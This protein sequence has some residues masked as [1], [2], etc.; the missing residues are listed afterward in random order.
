LSIT[1]T[2]VRRADLRFIEAADALRRY[3]G[4][5]WVVTAEPDAT[6]RIVPDGSTAISIQLQKSGT[7]GWVL[8]GPMVR[9]EERRFRSRAMLIGVRLRP[10]VAFLVSGIAAHTIVGRHVRLS[11]T[12]AFHALAGEEPLARTPFQYIDI[13]QSFLAER[14]TTANMHIVVAKAMEEIQQAHGCVRVAEVAARCGVSPRHLNRL[15]RIWVGYGPK[16]FGRIVRFQETLKQMEHSPSRSAAALASE[17]GYFDQAH[18]TL[19]LARFAA[20]TPRHLASSCVADFSKTRCD[21]PL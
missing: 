12:T 20:A 3:V 11:G 6:I 14:L 18:L 16:C 17:T 9:P 13:L 19:D 8:R 7:S 4:C 1:S 10:G 21:D 2:L 15:M 5:F